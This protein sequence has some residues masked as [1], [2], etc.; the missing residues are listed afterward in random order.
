MAAPETHQA[1]PISFTPNFSW[2]WVE[3]EEPQ[4]LQRFSTAA[5][6]A[7]QVERI[8]ATV[9]GGASPQP[10]NGNWV[11]MRVPI[12]LPKTAKS[13]LSG[14]NPPAWRWP[15]AKRSPPGPWP[16]NHPTPR[17]DN[18]DLD[19]GGR[20]QRRHRFPSVALLPKAAWRCASRR[21]PYPAAAAPAALCSTAFLFGSL[22]HGSS[23]AGAVGQK[24]GPRLR[25]ETRA[26][27]P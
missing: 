10:P 3:P 13:R 2:V 17:A 7:D 26:F 21:T 27:R 1:F 15:K 4:P 6:R 25:G 12:T 11:L 18:K 20:A 8:V 24:N 16:R 5:A 23:L 14:Q 19:C 9:G 22:L